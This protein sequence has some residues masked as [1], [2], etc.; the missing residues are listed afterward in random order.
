[1]PGG[2]YLDY[3]N[4]CGKSHFTV[5]RAIAWARNSVMGEK[6][7]LLQLSLLS[8]FGLHKQLFLGLISPEWTV[9]LNCELR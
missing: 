5:E 7:P 4:C 9:P 8:A 1:M 2:D 6:W 3:I